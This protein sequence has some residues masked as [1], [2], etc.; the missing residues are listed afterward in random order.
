MF[1]DD[2]VRGTLIPSIAIFG[3]ITGGV[4]TF[5]GFWNLFLNRKSHRVKLR[6]EMVAASHEDS[7]RGLR[8]EEW[9]IHYRTHW[10]DA[11]APEGR[12]ADAG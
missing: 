12:P 7:T 11:P 1:D 3:A 5:L 10:V 8:L 9:A 4:G 2:F 6:A